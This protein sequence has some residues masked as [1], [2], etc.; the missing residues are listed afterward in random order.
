ME[1][2]MA[3]DKK[4]IDQLLTDYKKPER[5]DRNGKLANDQDRLILIQIP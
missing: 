5:S 4:L 1:D 2:P 3:I